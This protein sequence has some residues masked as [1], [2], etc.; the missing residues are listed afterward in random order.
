[1]PKFL[2]AA[3]VDLIINPPLHY[4]TGWFYIIYESVSEYVLVI[5]EVVVY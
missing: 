4:P 2:T 1:M 3:C 5:L